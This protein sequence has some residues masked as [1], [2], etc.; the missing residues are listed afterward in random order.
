MDETKTY[1]DLVWELIKDY[2]IGCKTRR[3]WMKLHHGKHGEHPI[4]KY[5]NMSYTD[6]I[7]ITPHFTRRLYPFSEE[8]DIRCYNF[9][10]MISNYKLFRCLR[11]LPDCYDRVAL[12]G[13]YSKVI[14][15]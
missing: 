5:H 1:D 11:R 13:Y 7:L 10:R 3:Y 2:L 12:S 14:V 6:E 8:C 9:Q 4:I 15:K